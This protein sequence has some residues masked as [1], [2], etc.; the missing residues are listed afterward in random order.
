MVWYKIFFYDSKIKLAIL[1][2]TYNCLQGFS[3]QNMSQEGWDNEA[4]SGTI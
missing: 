3:V 2:E 1:I 4:G